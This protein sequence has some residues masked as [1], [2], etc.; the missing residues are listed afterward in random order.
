MYVMNVFNA[1]SLNSNSK[2]YYYTGCLK[3]NHLWRFNDWSPMSKAMTTLDYY[4]FHKTPKGK[5]TWG[6][7]CI[8]IGYSFLVHRVLQILT[9]KITRICP[10]TVSISIAKCI[11]RARSPR[12]V[13]YNNWSYCTF[14]CREVTPLSSS[15][16]EKTIIPASKFL[17]LFIGSRKAHFNSM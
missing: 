9:Y 13:H 4:C 7:V 15:S 10:I 14:H 2:L 11:S 1:T 16:W 5:V 6:N 12:E 17:T 3:K 8:T